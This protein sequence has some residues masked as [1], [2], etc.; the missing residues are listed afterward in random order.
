[1]SDEP[2]NRPVL[3]CPACHQGEL[4]DM[5]DGT[6]RCPNCDERYAAPQ[7]VCPYC[8]AVNEPGA[9]QCAA[10]GRSLVHTCPRCGTLNRV[11][12]ETCVSCGL[13]FDVV[14]HITAREQMRFEDRFTLRAHDITEAKARQVEASR[15]Q[16]DRFWEEERQRQAALAAQ[17]VRQKQ[18]ERRL[19]IGAV[20]LL[21]VVIV[22]ILLVI[23]ATQG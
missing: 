1:M 13:H 7:R 20:T 6:L 15:Q 18:Q 5:Q 17:Q 19:M 12:T 2:A 16:L 9:Q 14:G 23:I 10:C 21:V 3:I 4:Q 8:D 22:I 11:T